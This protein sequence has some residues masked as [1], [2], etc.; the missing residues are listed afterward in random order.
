MDQI[1]K[2]TILS[3]AL[4]VMLSSCAGPAVDSKAQEQK[5]SRNGMQPNF[6][7]YASMNYAQSF[8]RAKQSGKP[9]LIYFNAIGSV[10]CRQ[11]E[12]KLDASGV[13]K[14]MINENF[15]LVILYVDDRTL[16][17]ESAWVERAGRPLKTVGAVNNYI[18]IDKTQTGSQPKFSIFDQDENLVDMMRNGSEQEL[19]TFLTK[20]I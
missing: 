14:K 8:Q 15:E 16:L 17:D 9:I 12:R 18:Q 3:A 13:L 20:N 19:L 11:F 6:E 2:A 10:N 4:L 5:V 7:A 1:L